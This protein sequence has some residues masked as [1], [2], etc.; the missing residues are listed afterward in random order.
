MPL[1]ALAVALAALLE[2][3]TLLVGAED[4]PAQLHGPEAQFCERID[5]LIELMNVFEGFSDALFPFIQ[6]RSLTEM[7]T[8]IEVARKLG[9]KR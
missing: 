9:A 5:N 4:P 3:R 7:K 2:C 1:V 6:E 8:L